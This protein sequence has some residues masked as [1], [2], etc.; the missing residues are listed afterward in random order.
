MENWESIYENLISFSC[1]QI[2]FRNK[3]T[4][5]ETKID[6]KYIMGAAHSCCMFPKF[7]ESLVKSYVFRVYHRPPYTNFNPLNSANVFKHIE[8]VEKR[9]DD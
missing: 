5:F 9:Q 6:Q 4:V 8:V 3:T 7:F 1:S 2:S